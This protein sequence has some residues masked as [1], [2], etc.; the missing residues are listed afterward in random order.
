MT[1]RIPAL[2]AVAALA[3]GAAACTPAEQDKV[4][5]DANEAAARTGE[6][7]QEAGTVVKEEASQVGSAVAA[8]AGEA[9]Q[10]VDETT[11]ALARR[12]DQ[13]KAETHADT[14]GNTTKH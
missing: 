5:A 2:A 12:A 3:L 1:I 14:T 9:A 8:G 7:A 6:A 11:D 10:E 4:Q 13:Q